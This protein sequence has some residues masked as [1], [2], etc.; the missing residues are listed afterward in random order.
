MQ[1]SMGS[2]FRPLGQRSPGVLLVED[3]AALMEMNRRV[4]QRVGFR[5]FEATS[6][7]SALWLW[8]RHSREID[9]VLTDV[10]IPERT[11][12]VD[13]VGKLRSQRADLRA[14]Y[15]SGFGPEIG[16]LDVS[17]GFLSKPY[18]LNDLVQTMVDALEAPMQAVL[19][20]AEMARC[21][22]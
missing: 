13:L 14:I 9:V 3:D 11:T 21:L 6:E 1:P 15:T 10:M 2:Q 5:V 8:Q 12:G 19:T 22:A 17:A 20:R 7:Q 18:T 4:L 16:D